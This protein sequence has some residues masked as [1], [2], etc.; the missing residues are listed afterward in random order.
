[1][2][3]FNHNRALGAIFPVTEAPTISERRGPR[4][5]LAAFAGFVL[6]SLVFTWPLATAPFSHVIA[7][8]EREGVP[9][10]NTWAMATVWRNVFTNPGALLQGTAFYP[11]DNTVAFSEH[12]LVPAL[13]AGPIAT[14]TG[15]WTFA[16]NASVLTALVLSG[17]FM[18]LLTRELGASRVGAL[19][20]G[21]LY[22]F[23]TW[24][25][26][27]VV[28]SQILSNEFFPLALLACVRFG[29]RPTWPR[30]L[31][32]GGAGL[33][34][35]LSCMYWA[36]YLPF[37]LIPV[38][39]SLVGSR[40]RALFQAGAAL[41]GAAGLVL[42]I[43]WPYVSIGRAFG[44]ERA[45]PESVPLDRYFQ[46]LPANLLY[47]ALLPQGLVNQNAAHFQGFLALAL[48][49]PGALFLWRRHRGLAAAL[50]GLALFSLVASLGPDIFVTGRRLGPGL[51]GWLFEYLPAFRQIRYPERFAIFVN[52]TVAILAALGLGVMDLRSRR[53]A[54]VIAF[55]A[56]FEHLSIPQFLDEMPP[57]N[58]SR[59]VYAAVREL[60]EG[61]VV[62]EVPATRYR[63]ERR[64]AI[65]MFQ[66]I[67]HRKRT[68]EGYTGY[69]PPLYTLAK[70]HL[71]NFP[72]ARSVKF[73]SDFG[74]TA[75]VDRS[76]Q[77]LPP[78]VSILGSFG[79]ARLLRLPPRAP[80][81]F[82]DDSFLSRPEWDEIPRAG[83]EIR[84]PERDANTMVLLDND[85][86]TVWST[87]GEQTRAAFV[88]VRFKSPERLGR[89]RLFLPP[90]AEFPISFRVEGLVDSEER[91][92]V[93]AYDADWAFT[94]LARTLWKTPLAAF[95]DIDLDPV[96]V[97]GFRIRVIEDNPF[98][99]P[100]TISEVRAY[101]APR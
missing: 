100:I 17:F 30:A 48:C 4:E 29:A 49:V 52:L 89:I 3:H 88:R 36:V 13:M 90:P 45:I 12:L 64:D 75:I 99:L 80:G 67:G 1:M 59:D 86:R 22:A 43:V 25:I 94:S 83:W 76:D 39:L 10:L 35:A 33:L 11:Y 28:R 44:Y 21:G 38:L 20:G 5:A 82:M 98:R 41:L 63:M 55:G 77:P 19:L 24:N 97:S 23:N 8:A 42:A 16:Y 79:D 91:S 70:W 101:R 62:A 78:E 57:L 26:N 31:A 27:E 96:L 72:S 7:H 32:V 56:L 2:T 85:S 93:L 58:Q 60:P 40:A 66:S 51:Y 84:L 54:W 46:V 69:F 9:P 50:L 34:Q 14:V 53:L 73:L 6:L 81:S 87:V 15:S 18:F 61:A 74:V 71:F 47:G 92:P 68:V 37:L 65:L 95:M